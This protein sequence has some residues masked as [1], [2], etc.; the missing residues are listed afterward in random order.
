VLE[1]LDRD[2]ALSTIWDQ[3]SSTRFTV[4]SRPSQRRDYNTHNRRTDST[5]S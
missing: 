5:Q 4:V 3:H 2:R 1:S